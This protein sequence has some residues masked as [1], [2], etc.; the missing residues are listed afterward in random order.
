M[1]KSLI[2]AGMTNWN[3]IKF[4][5]DFLLGFAPPP[6][7]KKMW[8]IVGYYPGVWTL[9]SLNTAEALQR[10]IELIG[11]LIGKVIP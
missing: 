7:K 2:I 3:W 8:C 9:Y 4:G 1:K 10:Q 6:Q 11:C 5:A